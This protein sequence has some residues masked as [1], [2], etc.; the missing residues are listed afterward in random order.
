MRF[1]ALSFIIT[2]IVFSCSGSENIDVPLVDLS[3]RPREIVY[4]NLDRSPER[5]KQMIDQLEMT[6]VKYTR[7]RGVDGKMQNME[8]LVKLGLYDEKTYKESPLTPGEIGVYLTNIKYL[9]M[10][11]QSNDNILMLLLEDDAIVP[12]DI[13]QE[14]KT[15]LSVVPK[16]WDLLYFGCYLDVFFD[17]DKGGLVQSPYARNNRLKPMCPNVSNKVFPIVEGSP[18]FKID[19]HCHS[20]AYAY[21]ANKNKVGSILQQIKPIRT[22]IDNQYRLLY[23]ENNGLKAYCLKPNLIRTRYDI[24]STIR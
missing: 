22:A 4:I 13:D 14:M 23:G 6:K 20:G 1:L 16:D 9:E 11:E 15:A 18:W 3:E 7:L 17:L 8:D 10:L 24:P 19:W 2:C 5:N 21:M 12:V